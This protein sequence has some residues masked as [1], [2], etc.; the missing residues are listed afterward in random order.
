M[1]FMQ[2]MMNGRF[3]LELILLL[4]L[5]LPQYGFA[6]EQGSVCLGPNATFVPYTPEEYVMLTIGDSKQIDFLAQTDNP[7]VVITGLDLSKIY[8]VKVY[9]KVKV[10]ILGH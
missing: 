1:N 9:H 8:P 5:S 2:L 4:L 6:D 3:F 7:R 10:T